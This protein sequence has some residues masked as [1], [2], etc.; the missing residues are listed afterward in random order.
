MNESTSQGLPTVLVPGL[1]CTPRCY[2]QQIPALWPFGPVTVA[3]HRRDDSIA[4]IARRI[5]ADAPPQ[6]ALAGISMGGY[7]ALEIVRQAPG[8]VARLAL[9]CTS[10]RPDTPE[11]TDRRKQQI[12][13]ARKGRFAEVAKLM[14]PLMFHPSRHADESLRDAL[15]T[16]AK[17]TGAEAF[18][19]QQTA[20]IG[21]IDSRPHLSAIACPT[22]VLSAQNDEVIPPAWSKE[23]AD[24]IPGAALHTL[25]ECGHLSTV[26]RPVE[27]T[28]A[29]VDFWQS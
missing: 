3:D 27:A 18:V 16:M 10:A 11:Q 1:L 13:L 19:R 28:Q 4:A 8:R 20:I 17:D 15:Q 24:G 6:F 25:P 14:F 26:D 12:D 5:L 29:L 23:M 22:F 21:R 9:I 7:I 2:A